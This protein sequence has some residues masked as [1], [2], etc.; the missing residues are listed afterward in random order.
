MNWKILLLIIALLV[1]VCLN[2]CTWE[3]D[4]KKIGTITSEFNKTFTQVLY[5]VCKAQAAQEE[6]I[7]SAVVIDSEIWGLFSLFLRLSFSIPIL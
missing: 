2:V 5:I 3:I 1:C 7:K 4:E 6:E